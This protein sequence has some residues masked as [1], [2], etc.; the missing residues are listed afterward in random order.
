MSGK[1]FD[2]EVI[3]ALERP[4]SSDVNEVGS[5]ADLALREFI[6][7]L[8]AERNGA[9][10]DSR[11]IVPTVGGAVFLG[12]GFKTR[13]LGSPAMQVQLDPGLGFYND[14]TPTSSVSNVS[15]VD[16]L[17]VIKPLALTASE[18]IAVPAADPVN[19][20]ID[21]IEVKIDRRMTDSS[22]R[23]V[24][25][26]STGQFQPGAVNKTLSYNQN[27]RSTVG[28]V[29]SINYKVG[30][31]AATPVA[32]AVDAGYVKIAEVDVFA[33]A[34][35]INTVNIRDFR[36]MVGP[37]G[38]LPFA[39]RVTTARVPGVGFSG[40]YP[41]LSRVITPPG[42][43]IGA[44]VPSLSFVGTTA[45]GDV[46]LYLIAGGNTNLPVCK[47]DVSAQNLLGSNP[48]IE[49][50]LPVMQGP[51]AATVPLGGTGFMGMQN[52]FIAGCSQ[53]CVEIDLACRIIVPGAT[54]ASVSYDVSGY[55][56]VV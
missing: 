5:Y 22:L 10:D 4:L 34:S 46:K 20:R 15:G 30:T 7:N 48:N 35:A 25:N 43:Q 29:G 47:I 53:P 9:V 13:A 56:P 24:L 6:M 14:N 49:G 45:A 54:A 19:P 12:A 3:N 26:V 44:V 37:Q 32:P 39:F 8:T 1:P 51:L 55:F 36:F 21:I 18:I 50:V 40:T 17:S 27:G 2:R 38:R 41:Q 28:G 31:P 11:K 16:D 33:N 23:D 42:M 52:P